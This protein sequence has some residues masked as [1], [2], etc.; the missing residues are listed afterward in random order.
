MKKI[1]HIAL[2]TPM[3]LMSIL[4][5]AEYCRPQNDSQNAPAQTSAPQTTT[6][7]PA[8]SQAPPQQPA[9]SQA[10]APQPSAL[11]AKKNALL[12]KGIDP[13]ISLEGRKAA[14]DQL[15]KLDPNNREAIEKR[16]QV[17]KELEAE[18]SKQAEEENKSRRKLED[19]KKIKDIQTSIEKAIKKGDI[20]AAKKA[21]NNLDP[22]GPQAKE[23]MKQIADLQ[24]KNLQKWL[25]LGVIGASLLAGLV[26]L[27][28][29]GMRP[30]RMAFRVMDG[31]DADYIF[32]IENPRVRV[33]S[34]PDHSDIVI[35]DDSH[36][37]SRVHFELYRSG[38]RYFVRDLSSNGT[39]VN[40]QKLNRGET[41][42]VKPGD[43]IS[44]ADAARLEFFVAG[45]E[46]LQQ[47]NAGGA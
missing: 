24:W 47:V 23:Y 19:E 10:A 41:V 18:K 28:I 29:R 30:K 1:L 37:I 11:D 34:N 20:G 39:K 46:V 40:D 2:I 6:P 43:V 14:L 25:G 9:T 32:P 22:T 15:I 31:V 42:P 13:T 8:A 5:A 36:R 7:Q 33:G 3:V 21:L 16:G 27:I 26:A 17:Y 4:L 45:K 12:L 35:T 44:L 38:N